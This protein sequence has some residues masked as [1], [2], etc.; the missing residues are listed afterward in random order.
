MVGF[1]IYWAGVIV[2]YVFALLF[3]AKQI[4]VLYDL[5]VKYGGMEIIAD[6]VWVVVICVSILALL[7]FIGL[8]LIFFLKALSHRKKPKK[9]AYLIVLLVFTIIFAVIGIAV[10]AES[11]YAFINFASYVLIITAITL[12][13]SD[14]TSY[15][16]SPEPSA[17]YEQPMTPLQ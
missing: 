7:F 5:S 15:A 12:Q 14:K 10:L 17:Y 16:S 4:S 13:I 1:A 8:S 11:Y 2:N 3:A 9:G 6:F